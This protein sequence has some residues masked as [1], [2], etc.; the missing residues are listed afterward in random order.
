MLSPTKENKMK[1]KCTICKK[2][3]TLVP[4]ARERAEKFGGTPASYTAL[5]TT[6][7]HCFLQ[8]RATDTKELIQRITA[9]GN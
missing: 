3:I 1:A 6:H 2:P 5:F 7:T 8:K 9:S 4:S